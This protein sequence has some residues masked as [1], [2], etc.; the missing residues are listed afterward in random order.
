MYGARSVTGIFFSMAAV[1]AQPDNGMSQQAGAFNAD[2][3]C[4]RTET[5]FLQNN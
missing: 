4:I 2:T 5:E 3:S 1:E